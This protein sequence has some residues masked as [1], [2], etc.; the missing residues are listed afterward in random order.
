L[1]PE[2]RQPNL[3]PWIGAAALWLLVC[4]GFVAAALTGILSVPRL[5]SQVEIENAYVVLVI[6]QTLFLVAL[7]P[8]FERRAPMQRTAVTAGL[9]VLRLAGL[10]I[11][12]APFILL[13]LRVSDV[14]AT[15][16]ARSQ[17]FLLL[18]GVSVGAAIRLPAANFWYY[19]AAFLLS[20]AV[21][22]TA[23]VLLEMGNI[24]A[25]WAS[26]VSPFWAAGMLAAEA[27]TVLPLLVYGGLAVVL[28]AVL[29]IIRSR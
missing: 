19:P 8:L 24:S 28:L 4:A 29:L 12:S 16:V 26:V 6:G 10:L 22:F 5:R 21:P 14:A 11:L 17:A 27:S 7:W 18:L 15:T 23:Y 2:P 25:K 13:T 9:S 3:A 1:S 20:A